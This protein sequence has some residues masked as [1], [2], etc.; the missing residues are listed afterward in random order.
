LWGCAEAERP[1]EQHCPLSRTAYPARSTLVNALLA[2][3]CIR[4]NR[5][6]GRG[7]ESYTGA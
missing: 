5:G 1:A 4:T 2:A 3:W 6:R 7:A